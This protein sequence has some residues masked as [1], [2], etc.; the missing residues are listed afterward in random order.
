MM[1]LVSRSMDI[2]TGSPEVVVRRIGM[3]NPG[4][5]LLPSTAIEVQC[6][7]IE[8]MEASVESFWAMVRGAFSFSASLPAWNSS[9]W[10]SP[11][12]QGQM[13]GRLLGTANQVVEP[14]SERV[15]ANV[16][17]LRQA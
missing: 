6:M 8:K 11:A 7:L 9:L 4:A 15:A 12:Q 2:A 16:E 10:W 1:K 14:I 5:L 3:M 13:V 17:R